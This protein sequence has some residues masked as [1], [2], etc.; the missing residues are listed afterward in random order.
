MRKFFLFVLIVLSYLSVTCSANDKQLNFVIFSDCHLRDEKTIGEQLLQNI[1]QKINNDEK[2]AEFAVCLG[3]IA[4]LPGNAKSQQYLAVIKKYLAITSSLKI[5]IYTVPGNHDLES[6]NESTRIFENNIGPL[7][8][9]VEKKGYQLF[10]LNSES[11]SDPSQLK[12]LTAQLKKSCQDKIIFMHKPLFPVLAGHA[13]DIKTTV[14]F[15]QM[16]ENNN[17]IAIFSGHEHLFYKKKYG[18]ILQ[19]IAGSAGGVLTPAPEG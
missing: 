2:D 13:F 18:N 3:D 5:P 1:V 14:F 9:S 7:F 10:F 16:F 15:K 12:W 19:V 17:V 11:L 8:F 6:G 4:G